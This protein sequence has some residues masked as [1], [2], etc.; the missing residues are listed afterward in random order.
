MPETKDVYWLIG[1]AGEIALDGAQKFWKELIHEGRWTNAHAGFT[2]DV[3]RTR[4]ES[5]KR[6]FDEMLGAGIRVPV[7]WGH[8]YDPRDNAGFLEEIE[9]RDRSLWGLL[10]VPD[11]ADA[12]KLGRTVCG[13]SVSV[14]PNFVD[15][16]GH[17]W[18]EVIE[19]VALTNYPV[20]TAQGDFIQASAENGESKR[21]VALELAGDPAP[22]DLAGVAKQL[23]I[24]GE[25]TAESAPAAIQLKFDEL[26]AELDNCR[27][28]LMELRALNP[29]PVDPD[30]SD[31]AHGADSPAYAEPDRQAQDAEPA[32]RN[33]ELETRNS[34]LAGRL[35]QLELERAGR[36]VDEAM[37][38]GK[39]TRPAA[40]A[41]RQLIAA[42]LAARYS[43]DSAGTASR[44]G[45]IEARD[46]ASLAHDII[47][48]TPAGAAVD[49]AE[50]TRLHVITSPS[51][52][53]TEA[54]AAQLA[55]ENKALAGV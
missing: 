15:G 33:L 8:S 48:G 54:K 29:D 44:G 23:G 24:D 52:G 4:L 35:C 16:T 12:Q 11:A 42:G 53:M 40:E 36:E 20:V 19:H 2:L 51:G 32:T 27:T 9:L 38:L 10:H 39:F 46:I 31:D 25:L 47:A 6:N 14:N 7:P 18:G 50:H 49:M 37:R 3:G 30:G 43:L 28:E 26:R 1:R 41:L 17:R 45:G 5:W 21:A 34:E 55:R 22:A 13:V